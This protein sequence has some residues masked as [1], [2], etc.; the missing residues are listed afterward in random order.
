[1]D[2]ILLLAG[3]AL[4]ILGVILFVVCAIKESSVTGLHKALGVYG[5]FRAYLFVSLLYCGVGMILLFPF[6]LM[7]TGSFSVNVLEQLLGGIICLITAIVLYRTA[8]KKCPEQLKGSLFKNM[9]ISGMGVAMKVAIFIIPF[10]WKLSTPQ[11]RTVF[12][13]NGNRLMI[14]QTGTVY[15]FGGSR[16]GEMVDHNKYIRY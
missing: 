4:C 9:V 13:A 8:L 16:V 12:D 2:T 3:T 6:A 15:N 5:R 11:F 10:V 1:M 14:D 7:S